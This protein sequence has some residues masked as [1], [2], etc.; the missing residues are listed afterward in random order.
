M[1]D[2]SSAIDRRQFLLSSAGV[3]AATAI[4][5]D[6]SEAALRRIA[7]P[8]NIG[9]VGCGR[10]GRAIMTELAKLDNVKVL[11]VC[12]TDG[13]RAE[14]ASK[15]VPGAKPYTGI[16]EMIAGHKEMTAAI[17]ATPTHLHKEPVL[18][19]LAA[20]K[21]VYCEAPLAH[22]IVDAKAIA[23]AARGS[24]SL[25]AC[26][27]EGRSNPVY[28]LARTFFRSDAVRD[29]VGVELKQYQKTSWRFP[30]SEPSR[31]A[32]ANWRLDKSISTGLPGEWGSHAFDVTTWYL[33]KLP[34]TIR[35]YGAIRLHADGREV[36]DTV[37]TVLGYEGGLTA[38][39]DGSLANSHEGRFELL[40][41]SN[42]AVKL[43]WTHGWMFKE[44]DAPT[45]GWEVYANRQQFF[46][47]E[48]ITLIAGATKL[49]EQGKLKDGVGLPYS[50]L[51]YALADF[52]ASVADG[53]PPACSAAAGLTSTVLGIL[54]SDSANKGIE[55]VVSPADLVL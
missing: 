5:P 43:A 27:F 28:K 3:L 20:G 37:H 26:G 4:L 30:S 14:N 1:S 48:G 54:A 16:T 33:D 32:A 35:T 36:H 17:V 7:L 9:I 34:R 31:E 40:R 29:P 8:V 21:H 39:F 52:A 6:V 42:A 53:K 23:M 11:A 2:L 25:F 10:Q 46:N 15:R 24:K 19:L 12:D 38:R 45:Q 41:G 55:I 18:A 49:A 44:A 50:S 47:D 51:Y 13:K 22:T